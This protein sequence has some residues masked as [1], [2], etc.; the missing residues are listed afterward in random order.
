MKKSNKHR[1]QKQQGIALVMSLIML[2][3]ITVIGVA[4]VRMTSVD[5]QV[6]GNSMFSLMVFQGA[7]SAL[8]KVE[9]INDR[10]NIRQAANRSTIP[11]RV[12][13]SYFNPTETVNGGAQLTSRVEML[14]E[15]SV[16]GIVGRIPISV[17][18][19]KAGFTH[20]IFRVTAESRLPS[21]AAKAIHIEGIALPEAKQ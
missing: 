17:G 5:T 4:S 20:Q 14:Y 6:S 10:Y 21:T 7:E 15:Q 12:P 13:D 3:L 16:N 2:L 8:G 18:E 11:F 1:L 19:G 9:S